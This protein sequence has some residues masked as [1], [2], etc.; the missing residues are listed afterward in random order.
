MAAG[1]IGLFLFFHLGQVHTARTESPHIYCKIPRGKNCVN[2]GHFPFLCRVFQWRIPAFH[3]LLAMLEWFPMKPEVISTPPQGFPWIP[4]GKQAIPHVCGHSQERLGCCG[5]TPDTSGFS[6]VG[7]QF[8]M[9][10]AWGG[11]AGSK[12][13]NELLWLLNHVIIKIQQLQGCLCRIV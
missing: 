7:T 8:R 11:A 3:A 2:L 4:E 9:S 5:V 12:R 10:M 1:E 13:K 6:A